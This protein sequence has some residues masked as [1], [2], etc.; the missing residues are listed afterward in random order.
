MPR[1]TIITPTVLRTTLVKTCES[2]E[3]QT[4][5][6]WQHI[7]MVDREPTY[8]LIWLTAHPQRIV[9]ACDKPHHN[10]GNTCRHNAWE[11][12]TGD[13]VYYLDDDNYLADERV[14]EDLQIVTMPWALFPILRGGNHFFHD[15]PR[16][17][18]VD[19]GNVIARR[20]IARWP[21]I[22]AYCSDGVWVEGLKQYPYQAFPNF[23]PIM[24]MPTSNF[25]RPE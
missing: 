22:E 25:A 1:Y 3:S 2:V 9:I 18:F 7:V 21:D 23:R 6:D 16:P 4:F 8:E 10:G 20:D 13:Y 24:V 17:C 12:A 14:L 15:P 11:L 19:T 5:T